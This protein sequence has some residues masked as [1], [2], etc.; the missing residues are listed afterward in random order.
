LIFPGLVDL[1]VAALDGMLVKGALDRAVQIVDALKKQHQAPEDKEFPDRGVLSYRGLESVTASRGFPNVL[2][3]IRSKMPAALK[4]IEALGVLAAKPIVNRMRTSDSVM[5]RMD[6]AQLIL[7]AGPDAAIIMAS[8]AREVVAPSEALKLLEQIPAAMAEVNAESALGLMLGHPALAVR[9]RAASFLGGRNYPRAG[10]YLVDALRKETDP[11][12]RA[13][14][15]ETL[16]MLRY[17]PGLATLGSILESRGETD[18]VRCIAAA[19]L[20]NLGK[21]AAVPMLVRASA[22]GR[23]L[24]LVLN[25]APTAVRAAAV[26]ALSNFPRQPETREAFR[27]A[28]DDPDAV[29]RDAARESVVLPMVKVF[30]DA[31]RKAFPVTDL[32][33]V[34]AGADASFTGLLS[35]VPLDL[36][37]QTLEEGGRTGLLMLNVG[38]SNASIW[39]HKGDVIGSEY[40]GLRGQPAFNQFCR[41]EGTY[42]VFLPNVAPPKPGPPTSIMRMVLEACEIRDSGERP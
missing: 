6:L 2:E 13:L 11:S 24:T 9:R 4:I 29:V 26:R 7:K 40:N 32:A 39:L 12:A 17:E 27:K 41:W 14:F 31:A 1:A 16:G 38:G 25:A 42:F 35:D 20:G 21:P 30:G 18:E 28:M 23:G 19:A 22:K 37:C 36:V 5:E 10:T 34:P 33:Q 15:V 3:K 8:E